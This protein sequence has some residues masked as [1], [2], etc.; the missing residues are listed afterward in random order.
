[1]DSAI[2]ELISKETRKLT[3]N[4]SISDV[5]LATHSSHHYE[6]TSITTKFSYVYDNPPNYNVFR[7]FG[8]ALLFIF[9]PMSI[10]NMN[11]NFDFVVSCF[12]NLSITVKDAMTPFAKDCISRIPHFRSTNQSSLVF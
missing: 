12:A 6:V 8:C 4:F 3:M 7:M 2:V 1:M 10:S 5:V 11:L 9:N